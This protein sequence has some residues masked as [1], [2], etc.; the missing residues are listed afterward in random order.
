MKYVYVFLFISMFS[1]AE[2]QTTQALLDSALVKK[3]QLKFSEGIKLCEQAITL[4]STLTDAY[5]YKAGF[6]TVLIRRRNAREDYV[7]YKAAIANYNKVVELQP[8]HAEAFFFRGGAHD[9]MGFLDEALRDYMN[10]IEINPKQ[11]EVYNSMGVCYAKQG[12]IMLAL[13][14]FDK[15]IEIDAKYAKAYSNRGNVYD[16]KRDLVKAC[17]NWK[18]AIVLGYTGSQARYESKCK[19][20]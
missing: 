4:D 10:S 6:H 17:E 14:H 2:A 1:F 5:F 18:R 13:T 12:K 16:M 11:A 19:Q 3:E 20:Q 8:K 7:N 15:A 9:A